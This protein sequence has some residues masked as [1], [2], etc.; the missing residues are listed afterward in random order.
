MPARAGGR[1]HA[2][3]FAADLNDPAAPALISSACRW[4]SREWTAAANLAVRVNPVAALSD[5]SHVPQAL[6]RLPLCNSVSLNYLLG[7]KQ[8]NCHFEEPNQKLIKETVGLF[9]PRSYF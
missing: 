4:S 2:A 5:S 1:G 7:N 8:N 6:C 3:G 9:S